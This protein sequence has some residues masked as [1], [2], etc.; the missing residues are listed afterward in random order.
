[1]RIIVTGAA[2]MLGSVLIPVL[3]REHQVSGLTRKDC[4]LCDE[5]AVRE[6]FTRQRPDA[7]IHLA[8]F[9]NVDACELEPEKAKAGNELTTFNVAQAA[10]HVG[11]AMLYISTDY[12]FDGRL[13]RPYAE[14]DLPC[15]LSVYGRTKVQ[16]EKHVQEILDRHFI[17]RTSWLFGP[18]GKNFVST[19]LRLAGER[20]EIRV[21][22]D[23]QGA[24]TYT[25]HLAQ[26]L[27]Q[28]LTTEEYGIF[29][30]T[31]TGNCSWFEFAKKIVAA[32]G[33]SQVQV[34]PISSAEFG[35]PAP[36]PAYSVLA[37][38]RATSL[39]IAPLPPWEKGLEDYL[40]E[41]CGI[42]G[43]QV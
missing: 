34:I 27:T 29:H 4:D 31:G 42:V 14:D 43:G 1:M 8:A 5:H 25:R 28:L 38:R 16:G 18:N 37:N 22:N 32:R 24:P 39:G 21:V 2:G 35:R 7:V 3:E 12:V 23:Q 40:G 6:I 9:T 26:A 17:V 30:L 15:P 33:L 41:L 10:R 19:I 36:R 20:P 13:N 11:A